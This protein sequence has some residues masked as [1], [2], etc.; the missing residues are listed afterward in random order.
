MTARRWK[1]RERNRTGMQ[2]HPP[3][4]GREPRWS[5]QPRWPRCRCY[6]QASFPSKLERAMAKACTAH[7][8]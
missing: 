8:G 4:T 5:R 3:G 1:R 2:E 7:R 6:S